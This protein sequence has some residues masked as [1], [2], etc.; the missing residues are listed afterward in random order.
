MVAAN[1]TYGVGTEV[2]RPLTDGTTVVAVSNRGRHDS[3][4]HHS[5]RHVIWGN[6]TTDTLSH[7]ACQTAGREYYGALSFSVHLL[8]QHMLTRTV[9]QPFNEGF[10][11]V[12]FDCLDFRF[13]DITPVPVPVPVP[14]CMCNISTSEQR[15]VGPLTCLL[16]HDPRTITFRGG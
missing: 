8:P 7:P 14:I 10:G 12:F 4:R 3:R 16:H 6:L 2:N 1:E 5:L 11:C 15:I 9:V 13:T